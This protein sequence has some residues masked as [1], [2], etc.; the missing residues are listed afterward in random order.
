MNDNDVPIRTFLLNMWFPI[1]DADTVS[2]SQNPRD[3]G[4][5]PYQFV[6]ASSPLE[7][8]DSFSTPLY[9]E[10][11]N[12]F[13]FGEL[14]RDG[15]NDFPLTGETR[16]IVIVNGSTG[17]L[18][19]SFAPTGTGDSL[20]EIQVSSMRDTMMA[21]INNVTPEPT[22]PAEFEII[23]SSLIE[24]DTFRIEFEFTPG[25]EEGDFRFVAS[26]DLEDFDINLSS[27]TAV[28]EIREGIYQADIVIDGSNNSLFF[29]IE[30]SRN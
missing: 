18:L 14:G 22:E 25:L 5:G 16:R 27:Q 11:F 9:F 6:G 28:E 21:A 13:R 1:E 26:D 8:R 3:S 4:L 12:Y 15:P 7:G 20:A 30:R 10:S 24:E 23:E 2:A 19:F 17:E 29:R